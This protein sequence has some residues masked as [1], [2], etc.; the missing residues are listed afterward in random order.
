MFTHEFQNAIFSRH[1]SHIEK[2][3][4]KMENEIS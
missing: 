1:Y 4:N 3:K 2:E